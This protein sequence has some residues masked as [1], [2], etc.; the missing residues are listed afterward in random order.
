MCVSFIIKFLIDKLHFNV[1]D[2]FRKYEKYI[3]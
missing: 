1:I 3:L 2:Y